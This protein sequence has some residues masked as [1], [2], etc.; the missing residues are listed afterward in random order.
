M[1]RVL[2]VAAHPD[3]EILGVG[4]TIVKRV[5]NGD[6]CRA[7][8][9][10]EGITARGESREEF[11]GSEQSPLRKDA[12]KSA[13]VI[14]YEKIDFIGLPDV[15][16][17]S[18]DLLDIV[19]IV[20]KSFFEFKPEIVYTHHYGDLNIDHRLTYE[21]TLCAARPVN[22]WYPDEL[23]CFETPSSTEWNFGRKKDSFYPNIFVNV[24][25][26]IK[27][28]CDAMKCYKGEIREYPHPRS[29][30][31]LEAIAKKWGSTVN[32]KYAE[33]FEQVYKI[34]K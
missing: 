27:K 30:E 13:K 12:I 7:L 6:V 34:E 14:G 32:F 2:V 28:K 8:I 24:E 18:M 25:D 9:L 16:F 11:D 26:T 15:R 23:L 17:D 4:A 3:D 22:G 1:S 20:Q 21:A 5:Q 31:I 19:K 29:I 10:G 33:A